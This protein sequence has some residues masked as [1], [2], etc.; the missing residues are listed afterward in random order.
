MHGALEDICKVPLQAENAFH[1]FDGREFWC[2]QVRQE[3]ANERLYSESMPE[4][5]DH[6]DVLTG[7]YWEMLNIVMARIQV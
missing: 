4:L 7:S 3:E 1:Q 6:M 2:L 5:A